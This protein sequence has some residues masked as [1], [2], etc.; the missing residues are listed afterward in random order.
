MHVESPSA[1]LEE[2]GNPDFSESD[3]IKE[4]KFDNKDNIPIWLMDCPKDE[5]GN[6][7]SISAWTAAMKVAHSID[8]RGINRTLETAKCLFKD[9]DLDIPNDSRD[10]VMDYIQKCI[11]CLKL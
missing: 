8:H 4:D 5:V 6:W 2:M 9:L 11:T 7:Y 1:A 10:S 3:S